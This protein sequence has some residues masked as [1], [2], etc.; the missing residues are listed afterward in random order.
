VT[1]RRALGALGGL[2]V[3]LLATGARAEAV[4]R[5]D[6]ERSAVRFRLAATLHTVRGEGR[7]VAGELRFDPAGGA[8]SGEVAVDARSFVTG[9]EARDRN[10][11]EQVL[12]SARFP[13]IRFEAERLELRSRS[14][15][16]AEVT[17]H[18]RFAI[19]G[20]S[21]AVAVPGRVVREGDGVRVEAEL[22][23]PYVAWG[24]RDVSTFVLRVAPE[25]EVELA[26][27]GSLE[28]PAAPGSASPQRPN[29]P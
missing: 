24:L 10:M 25:V 11:H 16:A 23:L 17:L 4:L 2:A 28:L 3:S 13:E 26:L 22:M 29:G 19:H 12:E 20:G 8:A 15:D 6:P 5:I 9:I 18:G 21:H 1:R 27:H 7:V 14:A